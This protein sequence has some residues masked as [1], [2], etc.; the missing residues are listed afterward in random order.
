[1]TASPLAP[2]R[3]LR[4]LFRTRAWPW[5]LLA[6]SMGLWLTW[7]GGGRSGPEAGELAPALRAPW[8]EGEEPFDL[9]SRRGHVTVVAFWATWCP[10]CRSEGPALARL[11]ERI[12][13][14]GDAVIGVSLDEAPLEAIAS[15]ARR[16]GMTYP[17]AKSTAGDSAR[18]R[19]ELLPTVV[20][21]G[22][23]GRVARSF[24]GAVG[25][26]LLFEA[27]EAARAGR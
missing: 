27:V 16:F 20:V 1:M 8:T 5:L 4:S 6:A 3:G 23:D 19:I 24:V 17:I 15:A 25:E 7:D 26:S 2:R 10:A 22:P 12:A 11:H 9:A 13:P 21:V 18:F 14:E